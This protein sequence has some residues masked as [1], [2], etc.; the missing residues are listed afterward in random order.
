MMLLLTTAAAPPFVLRHNRWIWKCVLPWQS[1]GSLRRQILLLF[2]Y[3]WCAWR[4]R[5]HRAWTHASRFVTDDINLTTGFAI[6]FVMSAVYDS[7]DPCI[8]PAFAYFDLT[9]LELPAVLIDLGGAAANNCRISPIR[10]AHT[11]WIVK[12]VWRQI[13]NVL[14]E[15]GGSIVRVIKLL[16]VLVLMHKFAVKFETLRG[17]HH[18]TALIAVSYWTATFPTLKL[19]ILIILVHS[20][21]ICH[22]R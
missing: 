14:R 7:G 10:G 18:N 11:A 3:R 16:L 2:D 12:T 6:D 5:G 15:V 21:C 19:L 13:C 22:A 9:L 20:R 4:G 8:I 1:G 17:V